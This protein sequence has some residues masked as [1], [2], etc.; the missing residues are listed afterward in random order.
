MPRPIHLLNL[1]AKLKDMANTDVV[2]A[3]INEFARWVHAD[4][5]RPFVHR[6]RGSLSPGIIVVP[7]V[8]KKN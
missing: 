1:T 2:V 3:G 5:V 7:V 8:I 6:R 4:T